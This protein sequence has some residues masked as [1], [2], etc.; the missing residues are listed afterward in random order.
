[1]K[2]LIASAVS[3]LLG[4][5]AG[6][7][8]E[9][10]YATLELNDAVRLMVDA[11]ESSEAL[12]AARAA[13]AIELIGAGETQTAVRN[14]S[15]PIAFYYLLY[16]DIADTDRRRKMLAMI[17]QLSSTNAIVANEITN[18]VSAYGIHLKVR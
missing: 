11:G 18:E 9:R 4:L 5:A 10:H 6:W 8:I 1:M 3:L 12:Q 14:L 17:E 13:R 16:A 2:T 15:K 7:Q